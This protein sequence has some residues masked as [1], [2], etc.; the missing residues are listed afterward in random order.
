MKWHRPSRLCLGAAL[1][2]LLAVTP[3]FARGRRPEALAAPPPAVSAE[4][5]GPAAAP[6]SA[7][8]SPPLQRQPHRTRDTSSNGWRT[9]RISPCRS[10]ARPAERARLPR[11]PSAG[12]AAR[13]QPA[14]APLQHEPAAAR[15][16]A[17]PQ[18]DPGAPDRRS[19]VSSTAA[20]CSSS[21]PAPG[22][23]PPMARAILDL[24]EMPPDQREQV[25]DSPA[26]GAQF[27]D[28]E[29]STIRTLLTAEPYP[30]APCPD[31]R[32][33][34]RRLLPASIDLATRPK[35]GTDSAPGTPRSPAAPPAAA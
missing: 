24:R 29:R 26:F 19:S 11:T 20:P 25:I 18:R 7:P 32:C 5:P 8:Q 33:A 16:H 10:A 22:P 9:T 28:G 23:P 12:A 31:R 15:P 2:V 34:H 3:A 6:R 1:L 13:A 30:P 27:S 17:Q 4:S 14:R 21:T 35:P